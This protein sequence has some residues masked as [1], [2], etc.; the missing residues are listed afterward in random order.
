MKEREN[1]YF[2]KNH[3]RTS[4]YRQLPALA[5]VLLA[6]FYEGQGAAAQSSELAGIAALAACR[7]GWHGAHEQHSSRSGQASRHGAGPHGVTFDEQVI[8]WRLFADTP[9]Q[10]LQ[11][12]SG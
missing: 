8:R 1:N 3:R 11:A 5:F 10:D 9:G 2:A 7:F 4:L 12:R 6:F